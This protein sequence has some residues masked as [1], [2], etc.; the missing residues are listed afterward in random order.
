VFPADLDGLG[1]SGTPGRELVERLDEQ[2]DSMDRLLR[3]E[4]VTR[5]T[6]FHPMRAAWIERPVQ[7]PRPPFLV[8]AQGPRAIHVA[9][10]RA[11][12][13]NT[14]GGEPIETQA[15]GNRRMT[16]ARNGPASNSSTGP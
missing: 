15:Q 8:A 1:A 11:D 2:L 6:G 16:V 5:E 3:G 13:W 12:I 9:A 4:T 14:L 10:R 7:S